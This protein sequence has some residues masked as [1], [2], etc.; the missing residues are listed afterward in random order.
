MSS[1][2][3]CCHADSADKGAHNTGMTCQC[4]EGGIDLFDQKPQAKIDTD[5]IP[6]LICTGEETFSMLKN[7]KLT[8]EAAALWELHKEVI[9]CTLQYGWDN[10]IH[11][12]SRALQNFWKY[13]LAFSTYAIPSIAVIEPARIEE[14]SQYLRKSLLLMK[15]SP[16]WDGWTRQGYG[17]PVSKDN[18]MYKGHLN[19][20]YGLYQLV[21]GSD[22]FEAEYRQLTEIILNEYNRNLHSEFHFMGICCE[23]DQYFAPCN[24]VPLLSL[25]IHDLLFG[26]NYDETYSP[27]ENN[28]LKEKMTDKATGLFFTKYH[29]SHDHAEAYIG[30]FANA[31]TLNLIHRY[32]KAHYEAVFRNFFSCFGVDLLDDQVYCVKETY[33]YDDISTA[34]EESMGTFYAPALCKEYQNPVMWEKIMR[35]FIH[36]YGIQLDGSRIRLTKATPADETFAQNYLLFGTVHTDWDT[37]FNTDWAFLRERRTL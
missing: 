22:E 35:Y 37:I 21:S 18:I 6:D 16:I 4:G 26:T 5:Q 17:D 10:L 32:D 1:K 3:C 11:P 30:G 20:I 28:F 34:V 36:T 33:D 13:P 23:P 29:P 24:A 25:K 15:D 12:W 27:L 19:L 9:D 8:K 14:A 31:W 2:D 7:H